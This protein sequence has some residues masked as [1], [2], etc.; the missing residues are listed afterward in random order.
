MH[1]FTEVVG[2]CHHLLSLGGSTVVVAC[3]VGG[4]GSMGVLTLSEVGVFL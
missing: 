3:R 1:F 2:E 4:G